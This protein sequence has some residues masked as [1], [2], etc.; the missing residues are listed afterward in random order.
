LAVCDGDDH[1]DPFLS[2]IRKELET[3]GWSEV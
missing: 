2:E 1:L 3:G